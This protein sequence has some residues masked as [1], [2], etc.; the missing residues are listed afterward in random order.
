MTPVCELLAALVVSMIL[1]M[2][3]AITEDT[4]REELDHED[5][6]SRRASGLPP[7]HKISPATFLMSGLDLED[8][9]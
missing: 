9:Q 2:S 4:A 7:L 5:E 6:E 3:L 8:S 1:I